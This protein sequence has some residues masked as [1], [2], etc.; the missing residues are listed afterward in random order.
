MMTFKEATKAAKE[1]KGNSYIFDAGN[2]R[3]AWAFW[4]SVLG[5]VSYEDARE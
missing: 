3:K 4:N 2:G 5:K 1:N